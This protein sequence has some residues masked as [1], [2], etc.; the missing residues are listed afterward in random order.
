MEEAR[1]V[2]ARVERIE[3]L[4]RGGAPAEALLAELAEL[5]REAA[6]WAEAED[7]PRA[8]AAARVLA[9]AHAIVTA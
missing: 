2:L 3:T 6:A 1:A 8:K 4:E 7:D 5:A 9:E